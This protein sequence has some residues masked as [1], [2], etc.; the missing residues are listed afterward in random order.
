MSIYWRQAPLNEIN[1]TG[2][3]ERS[4]NH[5][6]IILHKGKEPAGTVHVPRRC[7]SHD[8]ATAAE[9]GSTW[10]R[11]RNWSL[12]LAYEFVATCLL[13]HDTTYLIQK[14]WHSQFWVWDDGRIS[15]E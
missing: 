4:T 10:K 12:S 8:V 2:V 7:R 1:A 5:L 15:D 9:I 6:H 11:K 14:E 3:R 13:L